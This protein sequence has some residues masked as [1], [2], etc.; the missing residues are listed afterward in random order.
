MQPTAQPSRLASIRAAN[1]GS[2]PR[3][4]SRDEPLEQPVLNHRQNEART[5]H[6]QEDALREVIRSQGHPAEMGERYEVSQLIAGAGQD[7]DAGA[8]VKHKPHHQHPPGGS[9][10]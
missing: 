4:R 9:V 3:Q 1:C 10:E 5:T 6:K 7:H 2:L 8:H